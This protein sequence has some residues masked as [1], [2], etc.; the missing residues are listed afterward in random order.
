M[1]QDK[2][3]MKQPLVE[4]NA[5]HYEEIYSYSPC[6]IL[7]YAL[8][9]DKEVTF[10]PDACYEVLIHMI[11]GVPHCEV[12]VKDEPIS[13]RCPGETIYGIR[14]Q[15]GYSLDCPESAVEGIMQVI[16]M[17]INRFAFMD[18]GMFLQEM[19]DRLRLLIHCRS[20]HPAYRSI[21]NAI[22]ESEGRKTVEE[23]AKEWGYTERHI[24]NLFK[25]ANGTGAKMMSRYIRFQNAIREMLTDPSQNN[26][27]YIENLSYSDQAHFQREFKAFAG[28]T[29]RKFLKLFREE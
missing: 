14:I 23:M 29:P 15:P 4:R 28:M 20:G 3:I 6:K 19:Q 18:H 5:T 22:V 24:Y 11:G 27:A 7:W 21:V 17:E 1:D 26:S 12:L 8:E 2:I 25:E 16:G 13:F 10:L 9:S